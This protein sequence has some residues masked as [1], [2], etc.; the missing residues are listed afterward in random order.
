LIGKLREDLWDYLKTIT[1]V[2]NPDQLSALMT[3]AQYFAGPDDPT[4]VICPFGS[5]C[6]L[7]VMFEDFDK[8]Q[9]ILGATDMAMRDRIGPCDNLFT[10]TKSMFEQLCSL[11]EKSFLFKPF[12]QRL[13]E[14]RGLPAL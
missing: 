10:V 13:R 5:G 3:G 9:A 14:S 8:P 12:W 1:F 4:P 6:S 2:V 11:D 7:F